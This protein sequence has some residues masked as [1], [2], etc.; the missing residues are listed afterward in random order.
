MAL[1][2]DFS[3]AARKEMA[4]KVDC[5]N[6]DDI[7]DEVNEEDNLP[8]SDDFVIHDTDLDDIDKYTTV[9]DVS[10]I[11]RSA[12]FTKMLGDIEKVT[13]PNAPIK[14]TITREDPEYE[15]IHNAMKACV[16][17]QVEIGKVHKFIRGKYKKYFPEL[18]HL[19]HEPLQYAR[20]VQ[21]VQFGFK[22]EAMVDG[23]RREGF[24]SASIAKI[25]VMRSTC[26]PAENPSPNEQKYILEACKEMQSLE[27]AKQFVLEYT[28][29][30]MNHLAPNVSAIVGTA[31]AAQLIGIVG[32][33]DNLTK[34]PAE[35]IMHLGRT[36]RNRDHEMAEQSLYHGAFL[37]NSDIVRSQEPDFRDRAL[38]MVANKVILAARVDASRY[39]PDGSRGAVLRE[40]ILKQIE[41]IMD[42]TIAST[43]KPKMS[44]KRTREVQDMA[45]LAVARSANQQ[46]ITYTPSVPEY[47]LGAPIPPS[48]P[49]SMAMP[50]QPGAKHPRTA[51]VR[52]L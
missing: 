10:T 16:N 36:R 2:A 25:I 29:L 21:V 17:L 50:H 28:Q 37:L 42:G 40:K 30:R 12:Q 33:L 9:K 48:Y 27:I 14:D 6:F 38:K 43:Y 39:A 13:A 23:L 19:V 35:H 47:H 49:T 15:L 52:M 20:C 3:K 34:L 41:G 11:S 51:G 1:I 4:S 45:I 24:G 22:L 18:E 8:V 44:R 26:K 46:Q 32:G 31:I 5:D 7:L